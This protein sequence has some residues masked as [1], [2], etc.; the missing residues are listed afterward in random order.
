MSISSSYF[1]ENIRKTNRRSKISLAYE[2]KLNCL[3]SSL[4]SLYGV[5]ISNGGRT[6]KGT[7]KGVIF[8][9]ICIQ[10]AI[11]IHY[12]SAIVFGTVIGQGVQTAAFLIPLAINALLAVLCVGIL[13]RRSYQL[14]CFNNRLIRVIH[15]R[16]DWAVKTWRHA[17]INLLFTQMTMVL[18][19]GSAIVALVTA[20]QETGQLLTQLYL[21]GAKLEPENMHFGLILLGIEFTV[22]AFS[23]M[24][25]LNVTISFYAHICYLLA[26]YFKK[27]NLDVKLYLLKGK[28]MNSSQ[29]NYFRYKHQEICKDTEIISKLF[30]PCLVLCIFGFIINVCFDLRTLKGRPPILLF[31]GFTVGALRH[32]ILLLQLF[33]D[34]A[35]LNKNAHEIGEKF[36]TLFTPEA[37][38]ESQ[39]QN[40]QYILNYIL[41]SQRLLNTQI[42]VTASGLFILNTASFLSMTGTVLTYVIVLYQTA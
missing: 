7:R 2:S 31:I 19:S 11:F 22:L 39:Q 24:M 34:A 18:A 3:W 9:I 14:F 5:R 35:E 30:S 41:F 40:R 17:I 16:K 12:S 42:G 32:F 4:F 26:L 37:K 36:V 20:D 10:L 29:L 25:C 38:L 1:A 21:P 28:I 33:Y 13:Y 6:L 15:V 27:F 23:C 8:L